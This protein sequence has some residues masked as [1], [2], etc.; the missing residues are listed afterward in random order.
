MNWFK[1]IQKYRYGVRSLTEI[2]GNSF[3]SS[4]M[5][6]TLWLALPLLIIVTALGGYFL[7]KKSFEPIQTIRQTAQVIGH[8]GDLAKRIE[9]HHTGDE[10]A[11]LAETFN[12]MFARLE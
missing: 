8:S 2:S 1:L 11:Q 10:L 6:Q 12:Q 7:T 3:M 9:T 4:S 5:I